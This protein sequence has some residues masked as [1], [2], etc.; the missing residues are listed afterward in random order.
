MM[1][2]LQRGTIASLAGLL[3]LGMATSAVAQ[4]QP[5]APKEVSDA[6]RVWRNF[7]REAATVEAGQLRLEARAFRVEERTGG[8]N[9]DCQGPLRK[10]CARLN[11]IGQR[12]LGVEQVVGGTFELL[13]S[14]GLADKAEV[15]LIIPGYIESIHRDDGTRAT[16]EDIGDLTVYGKFVQ[17]VA[18]NCSVGGGL[19]L[20]FPPWNGLDRKMRTVPA[21]A[22]NLGEPGT[23][24]GFSTGEL[25]INPFLST[26]Y[27]KGRLGLGAH[28]GYNFYTGEDIKEV[29]NYSA[30]TIMRAG[31]VWALRVELNGRVWSQ[32]GEKWHDLVLMPGVDYEVIE[33]WVLR[34]TGL[35]NL[36]K[37]A[38]DWGLG[39][40]IATTF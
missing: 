3:L 31:D 2:A 5:K 28:V 6:D 19:E 22:P 35:A 27:Q 14:Y 40:G 25:G 17:P 26:R 30:H 1:G 29:F 38:M 10:N 20:V 32:F 8:G 12:I 13:T 34:P 18:E 15:G 16:R 37:T 36:T 4:P 21:D 33:G 23:Y 24:T 39:V 7:T 9:P 11:T